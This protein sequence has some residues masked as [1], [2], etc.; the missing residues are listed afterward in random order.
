MIVETYING[1]FEQLQIDK[2]IE[3]VD[4]LCQYIAQVKNVDIESVNIV[5]NGNILEYSIELSSLNL[6]ETS[7]IRYFIKDNYLDLKDFYPEEGTVSGG[8]Y[9]RIKGNFPS[10]SVPY[11]VK[12]G[13]SIVNARFIDEET[14]SVLTPSHPEGP[15]S[16]FV[17]MKESGRY[18][19]M[20]N[21]FHF[22][23][24]NKLTKPLET[25][26]SNPMADPVNHGLG[27][28]FSVSN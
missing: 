14:L 4:D 10:S 22:I 21:M 9:V 2:N 7:H 19:Q 25:F 18:K 17:K 8:T 1:H 27:S 23:E 28:S 26:A 16:V 6:K 11:F 20:K 15:V 24:Y 13:S 3:T 12:F 5:Y